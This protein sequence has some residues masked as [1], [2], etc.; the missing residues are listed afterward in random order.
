MQ[1]AHRHMQKCSTLLIIREMQIKSTIRYHLTSVRMAIIKMPT[2]NKRWQG[3]GQKG[4]LVHC[5][6]KCKLVQPL[7]KT[8]WMFLKKLKIELPYDLAIPLL[9]IIWKKT[10]IQ[11]GTCTP[12]F[13]AT[14]VMIAK[15]WKQPSCPST[16]ER[17]KKLC[18]TYT[19]E[20]Y[21]AIRNETMPFAAIWVDCRALC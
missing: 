18:Y 7:W 11:K 6:W 10:L 1:M 8:V 20:Y 19:M 13:I 2:S 17:M 3:C 9:G 12:I 4:T 14:L 5:W 15:T 16:N 21:S